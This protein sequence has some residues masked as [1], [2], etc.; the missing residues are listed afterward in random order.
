M[1]PQVCCEAKSA[2]TCS[3]HVHVWYRTSTQMSLPATSVRAN[4]VPTLK[5]STH[6]ES[7][8]TQPSNLGLSAGPP[9]T[10]HKRRWLRTLLEAAVL[11]WSKGKREMKKLLFFPWLSGSLQ[12][13]FVLFLAVPGLSCSMQD[14]F[15]YNMWGLISWL[16]IE[17][18]PAALGAWSL[19]HWTR[20]TPRTVTLSSIPKR[21]DDFSHFWF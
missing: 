5:N 2:H 3:A 1:P 8:L 10:I 7:A 4:D 17:S 6:H 13:C 19:S 15:S 12:V 18:R 14:L 20:G 9:T 16:G 21:K 11:Q